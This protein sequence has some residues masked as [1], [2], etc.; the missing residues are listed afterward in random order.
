MPGP[1]DREVEPSAWS[2][3]VW[4]ARALARRPRV[5]VAVGALTVGG[6]LVGWGVFDHTMGSVPEWL[7]PREAAAFASLPIQEQWRVAAVLRQAHERIRTV[8]TEAQTRAGIAAVG[9]CVLADR[10]GTDGLLRWVDAVAGAQDERMGPLLRDAGSVCRDEDLTRGEWTIDPAGY[11]L[12][13]AGPALVLE[14]ARVRRGENRMTIE[15]DVRLTG[16]DSPVFVAPE[17]VLDD[18]AGVAVY[19]ANTGRNQTNRL[20]LEQ[21]SLEETSVVTKNLYDYRWTVPVE[22]AFARTALGAAET[23]REVELVQVTAKLRYYPRGGISKPELPPMPDEM[24]ALRSSEGAEGVVLEGRFE[25]LDRP[26]VEGTVHWFPGAYLLAQA[27]TLQMNMG[28]ARLSLEPAFAYYDAR[29]DRFVAGGAMEISP[30]VG[31]F[32]APSDAGFVRSLVVQEAN[33]L[34]F[35]QAGVDLPSLRVA[36]VVDVQLKEKASA[37]FWA[38]YEGKELLDAS[39]DDCALRVGSLTIPACL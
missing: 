6:A 3:F 9:A 32:S 19:E 13:A 26:V 30:S 20:A 18:G 28:P 27:D 25:L 7:E 1:R 39:L 21:F 14:R 10:D 12:D 15:S 2:R 22:N 36:S 17:L 8:G 4:R 37:R 24:P 11:R 5:W 38:N 29:D 34:V 16:D 23:D 33:D 35:E 31:I